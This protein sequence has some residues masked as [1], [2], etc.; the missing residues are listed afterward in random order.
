[1]AWSRVIPE[2]TK[3]G[4]EKT[5]L[6][7]NLTNVKAELNEELAA[8]R[9]VS[10]SLRMESER[11]S[12]PRRTQGDQQPRAA[13]YVVSS[14]SGTSNRLESDLVPESPWHQRPSGNSRR[15]SIPATTAQS[16]EGTGGPARRAT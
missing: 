12:G 15:S 10:S 6:Q 8:E 7:D 16:S 2:E 13:S 1:M 14:R 4:A 9:S 5:L 11:S 3:V